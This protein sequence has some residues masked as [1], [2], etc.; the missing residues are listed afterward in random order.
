MTEQLIL[1]K[2]RELPEHLKQEVLDFIGYLSQKQEAK[3][4]QKSEVNAE[5]KAG[6]MAGLIT[7]MAE[8]FNEPLEDFNE[9][10]YRN[11]E[12]PS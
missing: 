9:Y 11:D 12:T 8:D 10:M 2:L 7:Y 3:F 4:I 5:R 6:T 1:S